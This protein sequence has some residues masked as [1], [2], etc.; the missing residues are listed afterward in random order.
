MMASRRDSVS[1]RPLH[2]CKF[3]SEYS[4]QIMLTFALELLLGRT[5][6]LGMHL[7]QHGGYSK[8]VII[9]VEW[10]RCSVIAES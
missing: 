1:G 7:E 8:V 4:V 9:A 2:A 3:L 5:K 10:C 6:Y